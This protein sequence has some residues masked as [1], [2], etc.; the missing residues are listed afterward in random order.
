MTTGRINQVTI[1]NP[2]A[3][4]HRPTPRRERKVL[5]RESQ[6]RL[7][8][9]TAKAHRAPRLHAINSIAPT[10]FPKKR[11]ATGCDRRSRPK[12][13]ATY[14]SQEEK[15]PALSHALGA[16]TRQGCPQESGRKLAEPAI[17]RPQMAPAGKQQGF[18]CPPQNQAQRA[19]H[20]FSI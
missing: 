11:S 10:E 1:L 14:G 4:A 2:S 9:R 5:G 16:D 20:C 12:Q 19:G 18:G 15:T 6:K 8:S 17:H 7:Q 13:P 3:E